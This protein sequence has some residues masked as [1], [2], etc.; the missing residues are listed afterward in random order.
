MS[1]SRSCQIA[2]LEE[3]FSDCED[4]SFRG[5]EDV[6]LSV[7]TAGNLAHVFKIDSWSCA[8]PEKWLGLTKQ[9]SI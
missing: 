6:E 2:E 7:C 1:D 3:I 8:P 9:S 5:V 4:S